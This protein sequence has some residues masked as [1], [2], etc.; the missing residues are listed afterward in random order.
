MN[1][2]PRHQVIVAGGGISGL[3]T[4][5]RL[6]RAGVDVTL[7][8]AQ[9]RVGGCMQSE[10]R[11]GFILEKGPFNVL[12]RDDAFHEL[13]EACGGDVAPVRASDDAGA[14]Y[15]LK[16]GRLL[17]VPMGPGALLRTPLLSGRAKLRLLRGMILSARAKKDEPTIAEAAERRLG[18]E[19]ADTFISSIVAGIFGGD[20]RR[21]SLK[22]CFPKAWR[23]DQHRRSPLAYEIG[24]LRAKKKQAKQ[25]ANRRAHKGLVSFRDGLQSLA[26]W[27]A[28]QLGTDLVTS[29]R[30]ESITPDA[31][32]YTLTCRAAGGP[33][34]FRCRHLVLATPKDV[35][36]GLLRPIEPSVSQTLDEIESASLV[37][38]NLGYRREHIGHP[39]SGYGF[40]V[41]AG[42]REM[43]VMGVLWA[44]S[45]FPHHGPDARRLI[46][47]FMGGARDGQAA[48]RTDEELLRI[49]SDAVN[50]LLAITGEPVLVDICRWPASI[51]QYHLGHT[52]RVERVLESIGPRGNLH[53]V[54]NYLRGVSINDCVRE[55][56]QMAENIINRL[57]DRTKDTSHNEASEEFAAAVREAARHPDSLPDRLSA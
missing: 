6:N 48:A 45:A 2:P 51:P 22:A 1:S 16:G 47:V 17:K 56:T 34:S 32:G 19:V 21:L 46:R 38:L 54:G 25:H 8:E 40:L 4:A 39:M 49:A 9:P 31:D 37:V 33:R 30:A 15:V 11:D 28:D 29:C 5:W 13:L 14:R 52:Q 43:P 7:L 23:F 44:D 53:L 36:A 50:G 35:T 41:P 27:L 10:K 12:V 18:V 57:G 3:V 24:V 26:D 55:G 42:E 20:S